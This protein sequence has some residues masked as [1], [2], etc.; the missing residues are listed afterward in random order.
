M[1][2]RF[3]NNENHNNFTQRGL[4]TDTLC[5]DFQEFI[6]TGAETV[7]LDLILTSFEELVESEIGRSMHES[8]IFEQRHQQ[9]FHGNILINIEYIIE[10]LFAVGLSPAVTI[11]EI[12]IKIWGRYLPDILSFK[13]RELYHMPEYSLIDH[14]NNPEGGRSL[15]TK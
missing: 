15:I 8:R 9:I 7:Q 1:I 4:P 5:E 3:K 10:Y 12:P 13:I 2:D 11:D 14:F 6:G